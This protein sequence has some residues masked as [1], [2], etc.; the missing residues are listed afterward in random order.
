MTMIEETFIVEEVS[1]VLVVDEPTEVFIEE[2][3]EVFQVIT[4]IAIPGPAGPAGSSSFGTLISSGALSGQRIITT[5]TTGKAIYASNDNLSHFTGPFL[6][7]T[8][9]SVDG[10]EIAPLVLGQFTE[11]GW[12][13]NPRDLIYLGVNGMLTSVA[14]TSPAAEFLLVVG[15]AITATTIFFSPRMPIEI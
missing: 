6:F 5:D 11:P 2:Q 15:T 8:G 7:T 10:E 3:F 9:A 12:S 1:E 14:P 4:G 13:W